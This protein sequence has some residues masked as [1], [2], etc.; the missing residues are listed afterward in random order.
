MLEIEH[1]P[2]RWLRK[3]AFFSGTIAS[4]LSRINELE[5]DVDQI[6]DFIQTSDTIKLVFL[7]EAPISDEH[8]RR[9]SQA[10]TSNPHIEMMVFEYRFQGEGMLDLLSWI[11]ETLAHITGLKTILTVVGLGAFVQDWDLLFSLLRTSTSISALAVVFTFPGKGNCDD[12]MTAFFC[13]L[14]GAT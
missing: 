1:Q 12:F 6:V 10:I 9:V 5:K 11:G 14:P 2:C 7:D 4:A 3:S 13:H 8:G